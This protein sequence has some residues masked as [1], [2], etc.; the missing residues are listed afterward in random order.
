MP[1]PF[2]ARFS[3]DDHGRRVL[4]GLTYD[5]TR[6][7]EALDASMPYG[8]ELV[9]PDGNLPILPVETRWLALWD[10]HERAVFA[11]AAQPA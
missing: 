1:D 9:W 8:G 4:V 3:L 11:E 6:E 2:K 10:K 7:F 5:E